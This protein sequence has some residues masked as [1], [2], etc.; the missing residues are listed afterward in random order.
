MLLYPAVSN[1]WNARVQSN[2]IAD[3]VQAIDNSD[4]TQAEQMLAAARSYN[5][6]LLSRAGTVDMDETWQ[7]EYSELLNVAGTGIMGYVDIPCINCKLPIYHG[8]DESVLQVAVGH[9]EWTSLPVGGPSTHAVISGHRGLPSAELLTHIDRLETGDKFYLHVL[10]EELEY[11]VDDIA[12]VL[13][14]DTSRLRVVAGEDYVTLVTCTPYGINSHRLLVRGARMQ[15]SAGATS[16]QLYL[17]NELRP[18]S[19]VYV[20]PLTL[21]GLGALTGLFLGLRRVLLHK[22]QKK[23]GN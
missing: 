14:N 10:G 18:V 11:R 6:S 23:A 5:D 19:L 3:Y 16:G 2:A 17:T 21:V 22:R 8:T 4:R 20:I 15:N 1:F 7:A 13:P 9:L 12:V